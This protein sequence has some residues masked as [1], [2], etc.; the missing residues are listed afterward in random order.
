M[1]C[2]AAWWHA[3]DD[4][5]QIKRSNACK[6]VLTIEDVIAAQAVGALQTQNS[7]D[8]KEKDETRSDP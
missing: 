4:G 6:C 8:D 3:L 5:E 2:T 1:Q 7:V